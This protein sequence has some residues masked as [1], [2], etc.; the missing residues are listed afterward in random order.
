MDADEWDSLVE[1]SVISGGFRSDQ[2]EL[3]SDVFGC[4]ITAS[5]SDAA[6]L[7]QIA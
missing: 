3:S 7:E 2:G 1:G 4:E 5:C 6:A